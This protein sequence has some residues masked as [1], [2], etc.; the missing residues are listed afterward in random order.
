MAKKDCKTKNAKA[1]WHF[2][3][4]EARVNLKELHPT[5]CMTRMVRSLIRAP[6]RPNSLLDSRSG[7]AVKTTG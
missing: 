3:T 6:S 7:R 5:L 2:T 1:D 4:A